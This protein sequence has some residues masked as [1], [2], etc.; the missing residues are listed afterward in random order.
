[1]Q[2]FI[3]IFLQFMY[4]N[5]FLKKE[6]Y[7][8]ILALSYQIIPTPLLDLHIFVVSSL[9]KT[10]S[11]IFLFFTIHVQQI[12]FLKKELYLVILTFFIK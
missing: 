8:V 10:K 2:F 7:L 12:F 11:C 9:N 3:Y 6:L 5:F 4:N 1:M